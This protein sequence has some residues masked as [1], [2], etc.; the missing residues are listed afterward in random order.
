MNIVCRYV[1][2]LA[3][4]LKERFCVAN[5]SHEPLIE[6]AKSTQNQY[7]HFHLQSICAKY[8]RSAQNVTDGWKF[9]ALLYVYIRRYI[10]L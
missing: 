8:G 1:C 3:N 10:S 2:T 4:N 6:A 9:F 7:W 5:R